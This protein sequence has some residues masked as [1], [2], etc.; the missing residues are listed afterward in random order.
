[1]SCLKLP[2]LGLSKRQRGV[3][4]FTRS[5]SPSPLL[6]SVPCP[7]K[8]QYIADGVNP[9][10]RHR[11]ALYVVRQAVLFYAVRIAAG[12]IRS[13]TLRKGISLRT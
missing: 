9:S 10:S 11:Y 6:Y 12:P 1:M 2:Y 8:M 13:K 4:T 7:V 3:S 5:R